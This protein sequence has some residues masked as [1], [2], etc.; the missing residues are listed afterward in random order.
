LAKKFSKNTKIIPK[1]SIYFFSNFHS[2]IWG[3]IYEGKF[4]REEEKY[5]LVPDYFTDFSCKMG[6]C[7]TACCSG[8]PITI[9]MKNYFKLLGIDCSCELRRRIDC[10]MRIKDNPSEYEY[11]Q[12]EPRYDGNCAMRADDGRCALQLELGEDAL[13]DVCRLYPRGI[14]TEEYGFECSCSNSCEAVLELFL[15]KKEPIAFDK[16]LLSLDVPENIA[17]RHRIESFGKELELR[18]LFISVIQDRSMPLPERFF[19][20]KAIFNRLDKA[21]AENDIDAV[22]RVIDGTE[23][24]HTVSVSK[25]T[26]EDLGYGLSVMRELMSGLE[27]HS[28]SIHEHCT[29][30]LDFFDTCSDPAEC[31][32]EMNSSL[33]KLLPDFDIFFEHILVNHMFFSQFPFQDRPESPRDEFIAIAVVYSIM[34]FLALGQTLKDYSEEKLID[35]LAAASRLI[36]HTEFERYAA[37]LM[38]YLNC[39]TDEKLFTLISL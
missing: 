19:K 15:S 30:I 21:I 37:R 35:V 39:D 25:V 5:F 34:R 22:L 4:M 32:N 14:R 1:K 33:K 9:S 10:A 3:M 13:P 38:K 2:C 27:K 24:I 7:R 17:R 29:D 18:M 28:R 20:L 8:W 11:A 23:E 16:K 36:S 12:L 26:P 31:Y 6:A